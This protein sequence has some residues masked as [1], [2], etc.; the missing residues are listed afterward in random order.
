MPA[1]PWVKPHPARPGT[2]AYVMASRFEVRSLKDVPRFLLKTVAAWQ[3]VRKA[4]GALGVSLDAHPFRRVFCT[5]SAWEDR[6]ALYT[7]AQT[8]PHRGVMS[9]IRPVMRTS[10]FTFWEAPVADLPIDWADARR[11][12]DEQAASDARS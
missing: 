8:E 1:L 6:D 11:R 5:L 9:A 12:L 7:F 3:Q 4:P 2:V 10:M